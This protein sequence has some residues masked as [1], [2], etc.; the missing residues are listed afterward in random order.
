MRPPDAAEAAKR[1]DPDDDYVLALAIDRRAYLATGDQD[2][3]VVS[4]DFPPAG[5]VRDQAP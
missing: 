3:L 4:G 5:I 2:L 1:P